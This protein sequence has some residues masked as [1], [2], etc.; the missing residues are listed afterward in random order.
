MSKDYYEVLGIERGTNEAEIRAAFE[1]EI[2]SRRSRRQKSSDVH[3]AYAVLSD[4]TLRHAYDLAR[5]G[6]AVSNKLAETKASAVQVA[7]QVGDLVPDVDFREVADQAWQTA[8][9][10][11]VLSAGVTANIGDVVASVA[12]RIQIEAARRIRRDEVTVE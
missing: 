6:I 7:E 2:V 12:R 10:A 8:L 11:T 4:D 5:F 3:V 9:K 1:A